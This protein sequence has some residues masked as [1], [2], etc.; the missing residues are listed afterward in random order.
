MK[1]HSTYDS[2]KQEIDDNE[3]ILDILKKARASL[4]SSNAKMPSY[5]ED[6]VGQ[7]D[8]MDLVRE[9]D[10]AIALLRGKTPQKK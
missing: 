8:M 2:Y 4:L 5:W 3:K 10:D 9:V 6:S 1:C 7:M